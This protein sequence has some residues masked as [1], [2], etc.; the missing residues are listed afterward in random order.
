M[1]ILLRNASVSLLEHRCI[2]VGVEYDDC[3]LREVGKTKRRHGNVQQILSNALTVQL[4]LCV[5]HTIAVVVGGEAEGF[6]ERERKLR[7]SFVHKYTAIIAADNRALHFG[8]IEW[9]IAHWNDNDLKRWLLD[10]RN[11]SA[12]ESGF[13]CEFPL[14]P[15]V[16]S[17]VA[18]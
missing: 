16:C 4:D 1:S 9:L 14:Q 6:C 15:Y 7:N 5:E 17:R 13:Y 10:F 3:D 8:K 18:N 12:E 2:V 11:N